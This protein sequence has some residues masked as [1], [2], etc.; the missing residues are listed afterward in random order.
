MAMRKKVMQ[1]TMYSP[2]STIRFAN[3][4]TLRSEIDCLSSIFFILIGGLDL[5]LRDGKR[6]LKNRIYPVFRA[7]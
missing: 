3:F 6:F 2:G 1:N 4:I 7:R 5:L